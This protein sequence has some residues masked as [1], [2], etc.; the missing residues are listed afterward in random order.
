M[1]FGI[2]LYEKRFPDHKKKSRWWAGLKNAFEAESETYNFQTLL[3]QRL[4]QTKFVD[5]PESVGRYLQVHP[6]AFL[7]QEETLVLEIRVELT[8]RLIVRM[9]HVVS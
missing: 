6:D 7:F 3:A 2:G 5:D 4:A 8:L 1:G 9:R